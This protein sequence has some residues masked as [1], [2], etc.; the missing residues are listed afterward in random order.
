MVVNTEINI[1]IN[2]ID[3]LLAPIQIII[4]GPSATFGKAF[5]IVKYGSIILEKNLDEYIITEITKLIIEVKK[6]LT[7]ISYKVIFTCFNS[8]F[9]FDKEMIVFN[10]SF[11]E[12]VRKELIIS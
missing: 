4:K 7:S 9:S 12:D 8:I 3:F 6:K 5:I 10:T 2:I 1:A 11:G